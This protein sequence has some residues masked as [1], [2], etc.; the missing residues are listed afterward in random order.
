MTPEERARIHTARI[1]IVSAMKRCED[2]RKS[3]LKHF[4]NNPHDFISCFVDIYEPR[5]VGTDNL[6]NFPL[7][8]W[9]HQ[10]QLIYFV[11]QC[12]DKKTHGL[13]EKSRDMGA[14]WLFCALTVWYFI[15]V[16]G[17]KIGWGSRK[18]DLVDR[19]GDPDTI[20]EKIRS[21]IRL[22]P[23]IILPQGMDMRKHMSHMRIF[24][25]TLSNTITGEG[26]DEIGRGG[27]TTIYFIDEHASIERPE[28]AEAGL[29]QNTNVRI[30]L[31]TVKGTGNLFHRK[32]MA[33]IVWEGEIKNRE[34]TQVIILPW[35]IHPFKD[36]YWYESERSRHESEGTLD[37]FASEI[38]RDYSASVTG[39]I[40]RPNWIHEAVGLREHFNGKRG[41][42]LRAGLDVADDSN[43][44]DTNALVF[45]HGMTL[46]V[47]GEEIE[48][49]E[50]T[51][52]REWGQVDTSE[53]AHIANN[54]CLEAG[55]PTLFYD[56]PGVGAGVHGQIG[57]LQR[58][59]LPVVDT[60]AWQ[61]GGKVVQ[62]Y[63]NLPGTD[64]KMRDYFHNLKAQAW[65]MVGQQF[66]RSWKLRKGGINPLKP[67]ISI[68]TEI[69]KMRLAKLQDELG[70][71]TRKLS[72][73]GKMLVDKMPDGQASPNIADAA[74]I[75]I[76]GG[77]T[78]SEINQVIW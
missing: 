3:T 61:S 28:L 62:G 69:D 14:T 50:I 7:K 29:T 39:I 65:W 45:V 36:R 22:L 63:E 70:R 12:V 75:A 51:F 21:I 55:C 37:I 77:E 6:T 23:P 27:R 47:D 4:A 53:T 9:P 46:E 64:I 31:S 58:R 15:F 19:L 76:Y 17:A 11:T 72:A 74:I 1:K 41:R 59:S 71:A 52:A 73:S 44:G 10:R 32:R 2:T 16:P 57:E 78:I 48:G 42:L 68:S 43:Q 56:A 35:Q 26:G 40:I 24:H 54:E 60:N 5:N 66:Q 20:F 8:L 30:Y 67:V 33:G 34:K 18:A 49:I 25:P 38:D 13:V